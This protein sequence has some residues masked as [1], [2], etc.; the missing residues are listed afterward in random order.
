M[1]VQIQPWKYKVYVRSAR[2]RFVITCCETCYPPCDI[3]F[4]RYRSHV[5][6]ENC[7]IPNQRSDIILE[8]SKVTHYLWKL[9]DTV[10]DNKRVYL[11]LFFFKYLTVWY[12]LKEQNC[13]ANFMKIVWSNQQR[14]VILEDSKVTLMSNRYA[15]YE[16]IIRINFHRC[17]LH[18]YKKSHFY[19]LMRKTIRW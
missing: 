15:R 1:H 2:A 16:R 10:F 5:I 7:L 17:L 12:N 6:C 13:A 19:F 3:I 11:T 8:D 18:I 14:D 4:G 9:P